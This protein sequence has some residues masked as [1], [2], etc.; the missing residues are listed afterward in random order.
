MAT[1]NKPKKFSEY[2]EELKKTQ[3]RIQSINDQINNSDKYIYEFTDIS[4]RINDVKNT[5]NIK[6]EL[7]ELKDKI[8]SNPNYIE[9]IELEKN[10][11]SV[12]EE[13]KSDQKISE[14]EF[15]EKIKLVVKNKNEILNVKSDLDSGKKIDEL[16]LSDELK[17][18]V[19]FLEIE[20][21]TL[22]DLNNSFK[23]FEIRIN[24]SDKSKQ[25]PGYIDQIEDQ[26]KMNNKFKLDVGLLDELNEKYNRYDQAIILKE[27]IDGGKKNIDNLSDDEKNLLNEFDLKNKS[28]ITLLE[29]QKRLYEAINLLKKIK[30]SNRINKEYDVESKELKDLKEELK[31][32]EESLK[33]KEKL[34][35]DE[36][37]NPDELN[38]K[39]EEDLEN[40]EKIE[41]VSSIEDLKVAIEI[42]EN[43]DYFK[44]LEEEKANYPEFELNKNSKEIEL[45]NKINKNEKWLS[46]TYD[47]ISKKYKVKVNNIDD[48]KNLISKELQKLKDENKKLQQSDLIEVKEELKYLREILNAHPLMKEVRF[49]KDIKHFEKSIKKSNDN[50][51]E[52]K[53]LLD[54][55]ILKFKNYGQFND[56]KDLANKVENGYGLIKDDQ[57]YNELFEKINEFNNEI[58][59]IDQ[60]LKDS[61]LSKVQ[62]DNLEGEKKEIQNNFCKYSRKWIKYLKTYIKRE[63][64]ILP[65]V[66]L[67]YENAIEVRKK[68]LYA[69]T[70]KKSD[71]QPNKDPNADDADKDKDKDEDKDKETSGYKLPIK[72]K[73]PGFWSKMFSG[74]K[75]KWKKRKENKLE[76][77]KAKEKSKGKDEDKDKDKEQ[78]LDDNSLLNN[79]IDDS[80]SNVKFEN[81]DK[82]LTKDYMKSIFSNINEEGSDYNPKYLEQYKREVEILR[83]KN[84]E[85]EQKQKPKQGR[86][87]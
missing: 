4:S 9:E 23:A 15:I 31:K 33:V 48:L 84:I 50:I 64:E 44:N 54:D 39:V 74:I 19:E 80:N 13:F 25:I 26:I 28:D 3:K 20:K 11:Y 61:N 60:E 71:D 21:N 49:E 18:I 62:K 40:K 58:I 65:K 17:M 27:D 77:K 35:N 7:Q 56:I 16:K 47:E 30:Y 53:K 69:L 83:Q 82:P 86:S 76:K 68:K 46:D 38:I 2:F 10:I 41:I 87:R 29:E 5:E 45:D 52:L 70:N 63:I 81:E 73:E 55:K 57:E 6:V 59:R 43:S 72:K 22:K 14:D 24:I 79:K 1:N 8:K 78:K 34:I 85:E 66:A 42:K 75:D 12:S 37:L 32:S 36:T 51:K 67:N